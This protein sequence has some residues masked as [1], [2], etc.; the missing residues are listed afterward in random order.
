MDVLYCFDR[1]LVA[2]DYF[3]V[4]AILSRTKSLFAVS[5]TVL[6]LLFFGHPN[7]AGAFSKLAE[8]DSIKLL[9]SVLGAGPD[10]SVIRKTSV[11]HSAQM[12]CQLP[13]KIVVEVSSSDEESDSTFYYLLRKGG[14]RFPHPR[15]TLLPKK[16]ELLAICGK[17]IEWKPRLKNRGF[18][19][20]TQHPNEWVA[21]YFMG[22]KQIAYD[23][24]RWLARNLQNR[25]QIQMI[26]LS[27]QEEAYLREALLNAH[28]WNLKIILS[29]SFSYIQQRS[30]RMVD[31]SREVLRWKT[32]ENLLENLKT[33]LE[34]FPANAVTFEVGSSEFTS[35]KPETTIGWMNTA[36]Q[37]LQSRGLTMYTK[38]HVSNNQH[39]DKWGNFNFLTQYAD[40]IVGIEPH[41]VYMYGL[42]DAYAPFYHRTD[43]RDM[44]EF[45]LKE[46]K[47]RPALY[48][49][50]TSYF[51][52]MDVDAPLFLTSYLVARTDD[53]D[54]MEQNQLDGIVNFST[55]QEFGYW[56][57]DY[58]AALLVDPASRQ[59][60]YYALQL[61]NEDLS[62]WKKIVDW[63]EDYLKKKQVVQTMFFSNIMDELPFS[64]PVH[65]Q[66]V[67]TKI[68]SN[69]EKAQQQ[70][71][72]LKEAIEK[73]PDVSKVKNAE[74]RP[75]LEV[76]LLRADHAYNVRS[77]A[78][79][80]ED[81]ELFR[82]YLARAKEIRL[83]AHE[84][85]HFVSA[86][87][88]R[89]P[90]APGLTQSVWDNPTS[91]GYGCLFTANSLWLWERE[92]KIVEG[93]KKN[94][95]FMSMV[96]PLRILLPR[97]F[98]DLF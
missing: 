45:Y 47:K 17:K 76:T 77:A 28:D 88:N 79:N 35:T 18:H 97:K 73:K 12:N 21:G 40:T 94:P 60:P 20:H 27:S 63:Q 85:V 34:K 62:V 55:S 72:L 90:E 81:S 98:F 53:V 87:F 41:T 84:K 38:I 13:K 70:L 22:Q 46:G 19:L 37:Y 23:T 93:H 82:M 92:E 83:K 67:L 96:N 95:L 25:I 66:V 5:S 24:N 26:Q 10:I 32:T 69:R 80:R 15:M 31:F 39:D 29:V 91:Y 52:H 54:W 6:F 65:E 57:F 3:F 33:L 2:N 59:N 16:E 86:N 48:Y 36:G 51:I 9:H 64:K 78:L 14:F 74:H 4:N 49:P 68:D 42:N 89:Y 8:E 7:Q 56:L 1:T 75:L 58:Q 30:Y 50:E 61:I 43:Y 44:K 71:S 11:I